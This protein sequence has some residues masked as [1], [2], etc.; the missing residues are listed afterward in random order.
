MPRNVCPSCCQALQVV[1]QSTSLLN[2]GLR[3]KRIEKGKSWSLPTDCRQVYNSFKMLSSEPSSL[4]LQQCERQLLN[5]DGSLTDAWILFQKSRRI[6]AYTLCVAGTPWRGV[7]GGSQCLSLLPWVRDQPFWGITG[8]QLFLIELT[9]VRRDSADA[10][11][12]IF[13]KKVNIIRQS[14][15]G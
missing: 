11:L 6:A 7:G 4:S 5:I 15:L 2:W 10:N 13:Q 8:V 14:R 3:L 9:P 1:Q 12:K